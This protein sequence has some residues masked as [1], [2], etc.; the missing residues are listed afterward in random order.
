MPSSPGYTRYDLPTAPSG[1][2]S[3]TRLAVTWCGIGFSG[4]ASLSFL[5]PFLP[6]PAASAS[7]SGQ[8]TG[9]CRHPTR[10]AV[11]RIEVRV[12]VAVVRAGIE[13]ERILVD[14]LLDLDVVLRREESASARATAAPPRSPARR[15][16]GDR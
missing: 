15:A 9:D 10:D 12:I 14:Q 6:P 7:W 5:Q 4:V 2:G 13:R 16:T 3:I 11:R 8:S 1:D